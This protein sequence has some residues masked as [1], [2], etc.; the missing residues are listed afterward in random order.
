MPT[1]PH[2]RRWRGSSRRATACV[3]YAAY[4]AYVTYVAYV[5]YVTC[6]TCVT[7]QVVARLE[8]EGDDKIVKLRES[9]LDRYKIPR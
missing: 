5:A 2:V 7:R 1:L 4:A 6:F 9:I 3:T 8:Q